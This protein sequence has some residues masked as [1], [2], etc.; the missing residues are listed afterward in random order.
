MRLISVSRYTFTSSSRD[1]VETREHKK[2]PHNLKFPHSYCMLYQHC[3]WALRGSEDSI[4]SH[5]DKKTFL[6]AAMLLTYRLQIYGNW[7]HK[8]P[9]Y[10][11]HLFM[12]FLEDLAQISISDFRIASI[13]TS[14][15]CK[16]SSTVSKKLNQSKVNS[17][18]IHPRVLS[19]QYHCRRMYLCENSVTLSCYPDQSRCLHTKRFLAISKV[20]PYVCQIYNCTRIKY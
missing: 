11:D 18:V 17:L 7:S 16:R 12:F 14:K 13:C 3:F 8:C 2:N 6:H 9:A 19:I 5:N 10:I 20:I 15:R 4:N 1:A